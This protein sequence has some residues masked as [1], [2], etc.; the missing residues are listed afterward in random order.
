MFRYVIL[1]LN[2]V[3]Q[4]SVRMDRK[5]LPEPDRINN[6]LARTGL[7]PEPDNMPEYFLPNSTGLARFLPDFSNFNTQLTS[8]KCKHGRF[9][10]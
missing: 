2:M 1:F 4:F 7:E 9:V 6:I 10:L 8:H 5:F 3:V